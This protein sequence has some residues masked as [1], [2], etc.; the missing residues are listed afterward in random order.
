M[1]KSENSYPLVWLPTRAGLARFGAGKQKSKNQKPGSNTAT[2]QN[3]TSQL[4]ALS[5]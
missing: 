1:Q 2:H 3:S 4:K 5:K